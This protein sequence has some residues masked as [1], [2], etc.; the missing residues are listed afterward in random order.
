MSFFEDI[1]TGLQEAIAY[2]NGQSA[3]RVHKVFMNPVE[4]MSPDQVKDLR[5]SLKFSEFTFAFVLGVSKKTV[6]SWESGSSK[7][8]GPAR[9]LMTAIRKD[10]GLISRCGFYSR[11]EIRK[12]KAEKPIDYYMQLP[13]KLEI[14]PDPYE[15]GYVASYPELPGCL[16][17]GETIESVIV[18]AI[19]A[20]KEWIGAALEDGYAIPEP[21]ERPDIQ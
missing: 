19:D 9:R 13:Y 4:D 10:P 1:I 11:K 3:A 2:E 8:S 14:I 17:I 5:Q 16:T 6:E 7:P 15:G 18:N 12:G 21:A 20:K